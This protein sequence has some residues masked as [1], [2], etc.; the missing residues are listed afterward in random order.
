M[1]I[2]QSYIINLDYIMESV[3][4]QVTMTDEIVLNVSRPYRKAL[5]DKINEKTIQKAIK[6]NKL[7]KNVRI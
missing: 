1:M 5:K 4:H 7:M 6:Y 3:N 2:H